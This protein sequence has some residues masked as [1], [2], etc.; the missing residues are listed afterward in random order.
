MKIDS[1]KK[2]ITIESFCDEFIASNYLYRYLTKDER[3]EWKVFTT[4]K[5]NYAQTN[6]K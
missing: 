6:K 1:Y 5:N 2:T 3:K 4:R